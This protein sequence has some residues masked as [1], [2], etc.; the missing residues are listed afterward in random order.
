M[1]PRWGL[2]TTLLKRVHKRT[3]KLQSIYNEEN[4]KYYTLISLRHGIIPQHLI[5]IFKFKIK[6]D[7]RVNGQCH[8]NTM[9]RK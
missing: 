6:K 2:A 1:K 8:I 5:F 3:Q 7:L 4:A 9:I